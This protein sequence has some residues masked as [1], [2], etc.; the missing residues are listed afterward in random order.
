MISNPTP[1]QHAHFL[2]IRKKNAL[3][4]SLIFS[5]MPELPLVSISLSRKSD[6]LFTGMTQ[7]SGKPEL[8]KCTSKTD[9]RGFNLTRLHQL[10]M[11]IKNEI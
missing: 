3:I 2:S 1:S 8:L 10:Q 7:N 6:Y 5:L 11:D 4:F 9:T